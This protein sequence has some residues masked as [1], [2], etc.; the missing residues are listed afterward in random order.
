ML[1]GKPLESSESSSRMPPVS[2]RNNRTSSSV[3]GTTSQNNS[4]STIQKVYRPK[5]PSSSI[6]RPNIDFQTTVRTSSPTIN[7]S[8]VHTNRRQPNA[9]QDLHDAFTGAP[10]NPQL[11]LYQCQKCKVYYHLESYNILQE[12]NSSKCV[13]CQSTNITQYKVTPAPSSRIFDGQDHTPTV[14]TLANFK[15]S[16]N[17]VVTFEGLVQSVQESRRGN[18]FAVMFENKSWTKGFKLVFFRGTVDKVGGREFI[19]SLNGRKVKVRGLLLNHERFG[20]EIIISERSMIL[21]VS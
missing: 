19:N 9:L 2:S 12:V 20:Y 5:T 4:A 14:V 1:E 10:L 8:R 13:A 21:G 15:N 11:G 16:L 3:P 7:A 17:T 6:Q 18:D